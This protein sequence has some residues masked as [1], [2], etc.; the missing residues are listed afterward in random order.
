MFFFLFL[1]DTCVHNLIID[2]KIV[3]TLL[4]GRRNAFSLRNKKISPN[5]PQSFSL[6]GALSLTLLHIIA[7]GKIIQTF[8]YAKQL[9]KYMTGNQLIKYMT[10]N[11]N[12][13]N[14]LLKSLNN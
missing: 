5:Y 7:F 1:K 2:E 10:D 13:Y 3:A 8:G 11:Q 6:S 12:Y 4:M 9:I 14:I